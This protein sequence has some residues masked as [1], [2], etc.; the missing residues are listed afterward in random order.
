MVTKNA[1]SRSKITLFF[2]FKWAPFWVLISK[3]E[4]ITFFRIK[5]SKLH[6]KDPILHV[7]LHFPKTRANKNKQ[8]IYLGARNAI[9]NNY[10]CTSN[11]DQIWGMSL[12][13]RNQM[14][15]LNCISPTNQCLGSA[16]NASGNMDWI[17]ITH[18]DSSNRLRRSHYAVPQWILKSQYHW[19]YYEATVTKGWE[20][21]AHAVA[22]EYPL[23][24]LND[25]ATCSSHSSTA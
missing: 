12:F 17:N 23:S 24:T 2:F 3:K 16:G 15:S 21:T 19:G 6:K 4:I 14:S 13:S 22:A 5:L 18:P 11:W 25:T 9:Y 1:K 20:A 7:T 8:W 10:P